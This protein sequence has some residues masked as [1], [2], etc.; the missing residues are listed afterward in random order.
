MP[1]R[2][3]Q[4][5]WLYGI[6]VGLVAAAMFAIADNAREAGQAHWGDLVDIARLGVYWFWFRLVWKYSRNVGLRV[7]TIT[8]RAAAVA[9]LVAMALSDRKSTRLNSSHTVISYAVFCLKKKKK[10]Q[11]KNDLR[12]DA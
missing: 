6:P 4:V 2:L 7:W 9:G 8:A 11:D 10:N 12:Q 3:W 5:W 1:P